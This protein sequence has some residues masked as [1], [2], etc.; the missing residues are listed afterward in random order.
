MATQIS[1]FRNRVIAEVT[2]CPTA[3]ID[4]AVVD[5]IRQMCEDTWCYTKSFEVEAIDYTTINAADNDS[6]TITLSTYFTSAD[7]IGVIKFQID[8]GDWYTRELTLLNDNSNLSSI[9]IGEVKFFNFPSLTT[10]KVFPF[11]GQTADFDI[12][13]KLAVKPNRSVTSV[14]D[15]FYNNDD[16]FDGVVYLATHKLMMIPER[17]WS[18]PALATWN[19]NQYSDAVGRVRITEAIGASM[20][21]VFVSG[22]YF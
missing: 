19:R 11:T 17:P 18:N 9:E 4:L 6:I 22:G 7:P 2:G 5:A 13:M 3:R 21:S 1:E 15:M 12:F 14:E 16:W 8:G 20:G 10:I